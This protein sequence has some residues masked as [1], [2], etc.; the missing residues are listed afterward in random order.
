M[1]ISP[2]DR[3]GHSSEHFLRLYMVSLIPKWG[4][5]HPWASALRLRKNLLAI[6]REVDSGDHC[7]KNL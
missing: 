4:R 1:D 7:C 5:S 6:W 3:P 2:K